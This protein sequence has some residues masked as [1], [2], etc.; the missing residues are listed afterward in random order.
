MD[1][2]QAGQR[3]LEYAAW[4]TFP[5]E[6]GWGYVGAIVK[7]LRATD[8]EGAGGSA[9]SVGGSFPT[10]DDASRFNGSPSLTRPQKGALRFRSGAPMIVT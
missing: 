7:G 3:L 5:D 1:R 9:P 4:K 2:L 8:D 6:F 10:Y